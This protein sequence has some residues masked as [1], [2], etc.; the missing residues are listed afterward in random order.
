MYDKIDKEPVKSYK[1]MVQELVQKEHKDI[2]TYR[3]SEEK[4]DTK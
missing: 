1:T 2:P 3:D 4:T